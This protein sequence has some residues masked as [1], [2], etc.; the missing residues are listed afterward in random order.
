MCNLC[1]SSSFQCEWKQ[2][3]FYNGKVNERSL[4]LLVCTWPVTVNLW[5]NLKPIVTLKE[6]R[7]LRKS[8]LKG[9]CKLKNMNLIS[10][11]GNYNKFFCLYQIK[12]NMAYWCFVK[13]KKKKG[14]VW[15]ALS[16]QCKITL[17]C[18]SHVIQGL[19][20]A[21]ILQLKHLAAALIQ[22]DLTL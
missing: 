8:F 9:T 13:K 3:Q 15:E 16:T 22:S 19:L 12:H 10:H 2:N 17:H 5:S 14:F 20:I 7:L 1:M 11:Y 6:L 21:V 18:L 4:S